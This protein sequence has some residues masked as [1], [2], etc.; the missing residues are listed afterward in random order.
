MGPKMEV[1]ELRMGLRT[2]LRVPELRMGPKVL[3]LGFP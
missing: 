1:L 3:E 2:E